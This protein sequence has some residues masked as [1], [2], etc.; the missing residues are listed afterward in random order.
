VC[1]FHFPLEKS[2]RLVGSPSL[3]RIIRSAIN[4]VG[5]SATNRISSDF[6]PPA[7]KIITSRTKCA[8]SSLPAA[9]V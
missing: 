6:L 2:A 4:D 7:P 3:G 8:I 9:Q 1:V 5:K